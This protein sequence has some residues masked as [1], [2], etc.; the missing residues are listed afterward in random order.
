MSALET[1]VRVSSEKQTLILAGE[2]VPQ[3]RMSLAG[4]SIPY[5][6]S[7]L[8]LTLVA[9]PVDDPVALETAEVTRNLVSAGNMTRGNARSAAGAYLRT[10]ELSGSG[11]RSALID[12]YA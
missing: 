5:L 3:R 10:Q 6:D 7:Q 8:P 12:T 4:R 9:T 2:P 1:T 11:T